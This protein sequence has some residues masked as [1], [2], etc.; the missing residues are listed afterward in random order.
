MFAFKIVTKFNPQAKKDL[1]SS[2]GN[3]IKEKILLAGEAISKTY[4]RKKINDGDVILTYA[5]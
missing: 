4:A 1:I 3:F 5:L 2:L